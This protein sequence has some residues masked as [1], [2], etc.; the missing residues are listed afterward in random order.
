MV[1]SS[2]EALLI[3]PLIAKPNEFLYSRWNALELEKY[4]AGFELVSLGSHA[5]PKINLPGATVNLTV[6]W[7]LVKLSLRVYL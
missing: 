1:R 5:R 7:T 6:F 2:P 3:F 4:T